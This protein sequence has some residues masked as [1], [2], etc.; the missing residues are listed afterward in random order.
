MLLQRPLITG[1][2][3]VKLHLQCGACVDAHGFAVVAEL[4]SKQHTN[5]FVVVY[6]FLAVDAVECSPLSEYMVCH[7]RVIF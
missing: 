3:I 4:L 2:K 6:F 7:K 5:I 1:N